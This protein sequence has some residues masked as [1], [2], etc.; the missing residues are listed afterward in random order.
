MIF[1]D[2]F[3][4]FLFLELF[5][6]IIIFKGFQGI[7]QNK[8]IFI[9]S[10]F[11]FFYLL[12]L[13]LAFFI[14]IFDNSLVLNF[15]DFFLYQDFFIFFILKLFF[16]IILILFKKFQSILQ[17]KGIFFYSILIGIILGAFFIGWYFLNFDFFKY[18][19]FILNYFMDHIRNNKF[20]IFFI[21]L[22]SFFIFYFYIKKKNNIDNFIPADYAFRYHPYS[23]EFQKAYEKDQ[24]LKSQ[25][26]IY[27]FW[28]F[29]SIKNIYKFFSYIIYIIIIFSSF[30]FLFPLIFFFFSQFKDCTSLELNNWNFFFKKIND[31]N[32]IIINSFNKDCYSFNYFFYENF[33]FL[34]H[35]NDWSFY[36]DCKRKFEFLDKSK[37]SNLKINNDLSLYFFNMM[38]ISHE[39]FILFQLN[40]Y[41]YI[42]EKIL[43]YNYNN[44]DIDNIII[45]SN[46]AFLINHIIFSTKMDIIV[47]NMNI[48][49]NIKSSKK[50]IIY[51][52]FLYQPYIDGKS[53]FFQMVDGSSWN[54][55]NPNRPP[56]KKYKTFTLN[57]WDKKPVFKNLEEE[58]IMFKKGW[59]EYLK[60]WKAYKK[61]M[62]A[63]D[64]ELISAQKK[65]TR[66]CKIATDTRLKKM[67]IWDIHVI[68]RNF[69]WAKQEVINNYGTQFTR[70]KNMH[71]E[72]KVEI[73]LKY[74]YLPKYFFSW[75]LP[76]TVLHTL[77]TIVEFS[78]NLAIIGGSVTPLLNT[79]FFS[80]NNPF[81]SSKLSIGNI[82]V[83]RFFT[84]VLRMFPYSDVVA[85]R[86]I[87]FTGQWL[88]ALYSG[89]LFSTQLNAYYLNS[90]VHAGSSLTY[91]WKVL[92]YLSESRSFS[93]KYLTKFR[94]PRDRDLDYYLWEKKKY[95]R[96]KAWFER[97]LARLE[98]KYLSLPYFVPK[99]K[100]IK[101]VIS[102]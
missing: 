98:D 61:A 34:N 72:W 77:F 64:K 52:F 19:E 30:F 17:N 12:L 78:F 40:I 35:Y 62:S 28:N 46:L 76:F 102:A 23:V 22:C 70:I 66:M 42:Q 53:I 16:L 90:N 47:S 56:W 50:I 21:F 2:F 25:S 97:K 74:G 60:S 94:W 63:L 45:D 38:K 26:F 49:N 85:H 89:I 65:L 93:K 14:V 1:L 11:L 39:D 92:D 87:C 7:L 24:K 91:S 57:T 79:F 69:F 83:G 33:E 75:V 101:I 58:K 84:R 15:N 55:G 100:D 73:F 18:Q 81:L 3:F 95:W 4:S 71:W 31:N 32:I 51:K 43:N 86:K 20:F 5:S 59:A 29:L 88:F 37:N 68:K 80:K 44:L 96:R 27:A 99:K 8:G 67:M 9:S 13:E 6:L 48:E 41:N 54:P 10:Q 36:I 82:W